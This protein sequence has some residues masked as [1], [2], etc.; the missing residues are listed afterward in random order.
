MTVYIG[1]WALLPEDW[2]GYN[3]LVDKTEEEIRAEVDREFHLEES[4]C[5]DHV[6]WSDAKF[7]EEEFNQ[8]LKNDL[9][10]DKYWIKIF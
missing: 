7:F 5:Y 9:T 4:W 10:P 3:S 1:A 8:D 6:G 2:E